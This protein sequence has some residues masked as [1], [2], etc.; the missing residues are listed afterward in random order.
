MCINN[1]PKLRKNN[2]VVFKIKL[3]G[4]GQTISRNVGWVKAN[5]II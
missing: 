3:R 4:R 1:N 2:Y 5:S